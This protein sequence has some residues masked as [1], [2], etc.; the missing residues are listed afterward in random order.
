MKTF[1]N[2]FFDK[3]ISPR[4]RHVFVLRWNP[5][6]S[7]FTKDDFE[8]E[9]AQ[10]QSRKHY[11]IK[12]DLNWSVWDW[13][14]VMH[15]DLY[16]MMKVGEENSGI[17]WG[18]FFGGFPYQYE[19]MDGKP[20]G[21]YYFDTNVQFMHRIERTRI[22]SSDKLYKAVPN[23]DWLHG[24]SGELLSVGDAEKLGL[25]L[26]DELRKVNSCEDVYFDDYNEKQYVIADILTYMC[27][28]LKKRLLSLRKI[29]NKHLRN[30]NNMMVSVDDECYESWDNLE[31][32]LSLT[33]LNGILI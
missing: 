25:F 15:R 4:Q 7:S 16:V 29:D 3:G 24:H 5:L 1:R 12:Q 6:K 26:V 13:Q 23:V 20:G 17:V 19:N 32:H 30:I 18:G 28:E 21:R 8:D 33:K 10:L 22:L 31:E 9:F 11:A 27:P 2:S 14:E